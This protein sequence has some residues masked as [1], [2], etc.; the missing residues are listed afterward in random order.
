MSIR[1]QRLYAWAI[2]FFQNLLSG[3]FYLLTLISRKGKVDR[4]RQELLELLFDF[5]GGELAIVLESIP[6]RLCDFLVD[7]EATKSP[8]GRKVG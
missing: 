6:L 2:L 5:F 8:L 1:G 3:C 7:L 4:L